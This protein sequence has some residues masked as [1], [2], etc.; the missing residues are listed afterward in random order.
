MTYV[1]STYQA[2]AIKYLYLN[3]SNPDLEMQVLSVKKGQD[4]TILVFNSYRPPSGNTS[5][6]L[7]Q[8]EEAMDLLSGTRNVDIALL[9]DL[10]LDHTKGKINTQ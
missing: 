5:V 8:I 2:D 6:F 7:E 10:N 9:G 1:K 4:K 3:K